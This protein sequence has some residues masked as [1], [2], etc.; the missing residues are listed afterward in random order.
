MENELLT[1]V[2]L[3][4]KRIAQIEKEY[5]TGLLNIKQIIRND[6]LLECLYSERSFLNGLLK[7][8]V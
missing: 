2:T 6:A 7:D 8:I 5:Q 3:I 4:N 1:R